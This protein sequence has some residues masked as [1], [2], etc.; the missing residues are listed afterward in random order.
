ML[1]SP[2]LVNP[3]TLGLRAHHAFATSRSGRLGAMSHRGGH[4]IVIGASMGG[5]LAARAVAEHYDRVT[6]I[7]RDG[8]PEAAEPRKGVPR[9]GTPMRCSLGGARGSNSCF[10]A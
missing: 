2:R 9:G 4:A 6:V 7:E 1:M 8:V 3:E 10:R 5:L